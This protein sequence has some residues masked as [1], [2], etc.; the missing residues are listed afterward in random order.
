MLRLFGLPLAVVV[1]ALTV[2]LNAQGARGRGG[3]QV[4]LPD[5]PGREAVAATCGACH[6][7]NSITGSAGYTQTGWRDLIATMVKLPEP[8][9][10]TVT[11]Y[12]AA[13][14]PPKTDRA[15]T[16]VPGTHTVTF[17]EWIVPT[18]GQRSRDPIQLADGTMWWTG[19]YGSLIGRLNPRTGEMREFKLAPDVRPHSIA[20]D[21]SGNIWYTGNAN[22]TIG[23]LNP[24][25]GEIDR[26][27]DAR[28]GRTRSAHAGV[29]QE[30]HALLHAAA[31]QHGRPPDPRD[32][33]DQAGDDADAARAAVRHRRQLTRR[34]VG[35]LQRLQQAGEPRSGHAGGARARAA[36]IPRR[37][38][39][40]S[41][42]PATTWCGS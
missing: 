25:T 27:Q 5:G 6:G 36:R 3:A 26:L 34:R 7:L 17:R 15:P 30:R 29:R 10:G 31:E 16:L 35:L 41:P 8:Q 39:G 32:R 37:A 33:R 40:V 38:S 11:Q 2:S 4:E 14:F 1:A 24:A 13:N 9:V 21:A 28:S 20:A 12:L 22:G 18:L 23:R 19:Q 42:S